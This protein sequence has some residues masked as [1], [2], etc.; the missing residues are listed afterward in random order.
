M[1]F[2]RLEAKTSKREDVFDC[3]SSRILSFFIIFE[4]KNK[5]CS[6]QYRFYQ[7]QRGVFLH[8]F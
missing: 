6:I 2:E 3:L 5:V 7:R 1:N 8:A 4:G